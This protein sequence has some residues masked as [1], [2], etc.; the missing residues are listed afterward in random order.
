MFH[1]AGNAEDAKDVVQEAFVQAFLKLESFQG[2]ALF[3]HGCTASPSMWR[4]PIAATVGR[5]AAEQTAM[6]D[7]LL[8]GSDGSSSAADAPSDRLER[9]EALPAGA[10]CNFA[11]G[12]RIPRC[13]GAARTGRT[14]LR[15]HR[16]G[17]QPAR[18]HSPQPVAPRQ[19]SFREQLKEVLAVED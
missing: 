18:G 7:G 14:L 15:D 17:P 16:R 13:A 5:C 3:T 4:R 1:V 6:T 9:E 11:I 10:V 2:A 8:R 19:C 12:R